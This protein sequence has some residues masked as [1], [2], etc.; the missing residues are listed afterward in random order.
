M[1]ALRICR[2]IAIPALLMSAFDLDQSPRPYSDFVPA[3]M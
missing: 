1:N 2:S 3:S